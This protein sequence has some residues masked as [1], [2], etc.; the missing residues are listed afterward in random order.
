MSAVAIS[1]AF[2]L[3]GDSRAEGD[4]H[5]SGI[6]RWENR[7]TSVFQFLSFTSWALTRSLGLIPVL[8]V[9]S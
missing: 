5:W 6:R 7:G 1:G 8:I 3:E 9:P 4:L 2:L